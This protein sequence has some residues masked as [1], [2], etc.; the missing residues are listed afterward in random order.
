MDNRIR[1]V[2]YSSQATRPL[3]SEELAEILKAACRNNQAAD[4]TGMLLYRQGHFLQVLEGPQAAVSGLLNKLN[5]DD[6]HT[7]VRVLMD[8]LIKSRAFGAWSMAFQ[9]V[10]GV[11]QKD[12]PAYSQFLTKGFSATECVRYPQL[13]LRMILAFRDASLTPV[14]NSTSRISSLQHHR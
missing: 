1:Q 10:S 9:D 12:L 11:N 14:G 8:E 4:L 13:A 7:N 3:P 5:K 2:V 6:R